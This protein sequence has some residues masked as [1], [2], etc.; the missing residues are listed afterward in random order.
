MSFAIGSLVKTRDREWVVL[1]GSS[2]D[3]IKLRPLGGTD[4][5][6]TAVLTKLEKVEPATFPLPSPDKLGDYNSCAFLR[7]SLRLGFRSSA[8]P[9]RSFGRIAVEPRPYQLVPLLMAL[10]LD[11]IRLL[12]ADD[13]GIG[14]TVEALL[15]ARELLDRGEISSIAVL[16]PPHLAE[17]W[18]REMLIKFNLQAELVIPGK[19]SR[20]ERDCAVGESIFDKYPF[21]IISIDYI[22]SAKHINSF[23]AKCPDLV[24][25]DEAHSCSASQDDNSIQQRRYD[26]LKQLA[27]DKKTHIILVTA[28]PHSGKDSAFKS[29]LGLLD[30]KFIGFPNDLGGKE[31]ESHRKELAKYFLQRK[32][33]DIKTYL[34]SETPFPTA[35]QKESTYKLSKEYKALFEKAIDFAVKRIDSSTTD[36]QKRVSWWSAIAL[37]RALASSPAAAKAT[38]DKRANSAPEPSSVGEVDKIQERIVMDGESAD[39]YERMD[40]TPIATLSD[41]PLAQM[42]ELAE[43]IKGGKDHKLQGIIPEILE[44]LKEGYSPIV[45]CRFIDTAEYLSEE[46]TKVLPK[47]VRVMAVTGTLHPDEREERIA[48]LAKTPKRVL[49]ATDCLSEGINLQ[50]HF[51]AVVHYDLSWN[52]T[53]HEQRDGRVDRFGQKSPD[54]RILTYY[55]EDNHIDGIVL[56]ILL[57]KHK[58]IK[59]MLGVSVPVPMDANKVMRAIVDGLLLRRKSDKDSGQTFLPG[60]EEHIKSTKKELFDQWEIAAEREKTTRSIFNHGTIDP[61]YVLGEWKETSEALGQASQ[62]SSFVEDVFH[63]YG[64]NISKGKGFLDIDVSTTALQI[65]D[66]FLD[67]GSRFKV[68][69]DL[70]PKDDAIYLNRTHPIVEN[71]SNYVLTTALD[72]HTD[73]PIA[74]RAGCI[75]TRHVSKRTTV[76]LLR[77]RYHIVVSK[78]RVD[79][80]L[81]AEE[82]RTLAF[83]GAISNN[84]DFLPDTEVEKLL[85]LKPDGDVATDVKKDFINEVTSNYREL[86]TTKVNEYAK[87]RAAYLLS[88]HSKIREAAALKNVKY[89]V[90]PNL[91]ADL[92][93]V[94]IYLPL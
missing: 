94:Y 52:P 19:V 1:P 91:P 70:P 54:V 30:Q 48:E 65:R 55:G 51:N 83:T 6:S 35:I 82:A 57:R 71:I 93:G 21:L 22:K 26:L 17:Q 27:E 11:T 37:L 74:A 63:S 69:F 58:A 24:I 29:L 38:L 90:E 31:N 75:K 85:A 77:L 92:L 44:L 18:Q 36:I 46:L 41:S 88:S 7:E 10:K 53:R 66:L 79:I 33:G 40:V 78:N 9:F 2:E 25:V 3:L 8:G 62:L 76:L 4:I 56:D 23:I 5:E 16:C 39:G 67:Y 50:E 43:A 60:F 64:A 80:P 59:K 20:L 15:I 28:T 81:L 86:L 47:D 13:V 68:C 12:I 72:S 61:S 49:V 14:K 45:F 32:R 73:R 89:T 42:A 84:P 34:D 87:T